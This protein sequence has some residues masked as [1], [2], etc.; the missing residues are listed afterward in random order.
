M[1]GTSMTRWQTVTLTCSLL[2]LVSAAP[3]DK[4]FT[5]LDIQPQANE[6]LAANLGRGAPGNNLL[7]AVHGH[8]HSVQ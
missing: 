1:R 3:A 2:G 7:V 8:E 4:V 6:D 5:Y